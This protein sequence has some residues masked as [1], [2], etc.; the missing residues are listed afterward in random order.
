MLFFSF[1]GYQL[2]STHANYT[3]HVGSAWWIA[4]IELFL[5]DV[6][7]SGAEV[8]DQ[9]GQGTSVANSGL[10]ACWY[11]DFYMSPSYIFKEH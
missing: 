2:Q 6:C 8:E 3:Q 5:M 7:D 4:L 10:L 11:S 9:M 1:Q